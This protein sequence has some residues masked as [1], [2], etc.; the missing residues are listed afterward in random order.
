MRRFGVKLVDDEAR[1]VIKSVEQRCASELGW[2]P[3]RCLV[4]NLVF[5]GK[6]FS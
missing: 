4:F 6:D 5:K 3:P 1:N 2:L